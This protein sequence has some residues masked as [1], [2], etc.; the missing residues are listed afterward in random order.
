MAIRSPDDQ[1]DASQRLVL[2]MSIG[3]AVAAAAFAFGDST[4]PLLYVAAGV[5]VTIGTGAYARAVYEILR[6]I[7]TLGL[8]IALTGSPGAGKTV[9]ANLLFDQ[10]MAR[11][12]DDVT[13]T[14]ESATAIA[15][16]QTIRGITTGEWPRSTRDQVVYRYEGRLEYRTAPRTVVDLEIGDSAGEHW[17]EFAQAPLD[18]SRKAPYLEYVISAGALVHVIDISPFALADSGVSLRQETHDLLVANQLMRAAG[19]SPQSRMLLIVLSK[20]DLVAYDPKGLETEVHN[21]LW[22]AVQN[23]RILRPEEFGSLTGDL[24]TLDSAFGRSL[25]ARLLEIELFAERLGELFKDVRLL[26]TSVRMA[27]GDDVARPTRPQ[28]DIPRWILDAA[29]SG[30]RDSLSRALESTLGRRR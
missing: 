15:V 11:T 21:V 12:A 14:A 10:L 28:R 9:F 26:L 27:T 29:R 18:P 8:R 1:G 20:V 25:G 30:R 22:P 24:R 17:I 4:N 7:R 2:T 6:R 16:Y 13:F 19:G 23:R 3:V 5:G